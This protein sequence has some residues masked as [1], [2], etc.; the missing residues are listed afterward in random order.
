M[1]T[2]VKA[3]EKARAAALPSRYLRASARADARSGATPVA[4]AMRTA[5]PGASR[6]RSRSAPIGSSTAPVVP[7]K[8]RPSSDDRVRQ[9]AA[10]AEEPRAIGFPLDRSAQP[11]TV[12]AEH[13][14]G[15]ERRFVGGPRPAG[16]QQARALRVELGL[17]EQ[18]AEGRVREVV[19]R[20][21]QHDLGVAGHL[22]LA[23]LPPRL[24]SVSRRTSTSSSDDT[25][26]SSW[27]SMSP[28]R[29]RNVI[30]SRSKV[31]SNRSGGWQTG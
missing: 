1:W 27:V 2:C 4:K 28:S 13:V 11:R 16:E 29:R 30:L 8:A 15:D 26:M 17:D 14:E 10:A 23:G 18:L 9:R 24:V 20:A 12:H 5:A 31:A 22:E 6:M 7:D 19:L 25:V 21:R 3:I